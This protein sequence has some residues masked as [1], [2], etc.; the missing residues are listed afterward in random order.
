MQ[1][2]HPTR[3]YTATLDLELDPLLRPKTQDI[4]LKLYSYLTPQESGKLRIYG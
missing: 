1:P 3:T 4:D 2:G